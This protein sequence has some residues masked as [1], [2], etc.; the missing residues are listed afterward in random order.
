MITISDLSF[1][2]GKRQVF[3]NFS[4][5]IPDTGITGLSGVSGA[6]KT[7]LM[8][9]ICGLLAPQGGHISGISPGEAAVVFQE[10]RLMPWLS[11]RKNLLAVMP[12]G[13]SNDRAEY[14]LEI[15]CLGGMGDSLPGALSGGM[16]RRAAIARAFAYESR[17]LALDEPF[18]GLDQD[19]KTRI[20]H[21][22]KQIS[23]TKPILLITHE[24]D[25]LPCDHMINL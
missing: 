22:I 13:A 12:K 9:L 18:T 7:T 25:D 16:R 5:E 15:A 6:G 11:V 20:M 10:D 4:A 21:E 1:A 14:F 2:F 17:L 3:S 8:R 24:N 19:L 23:K